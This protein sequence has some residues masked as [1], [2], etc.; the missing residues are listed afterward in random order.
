VNETSV[1]DTDTTPA[2][3]NG[4]PL[5]VNDAPVDNDDAPLT[6]SNDKPVDNETLETN[7]DDEEDELDDEETE[8]GLDSHKTALETPA[9][10]VALSSA[11]LIAV[12]MKEIEDMKTE[13]ARTARAHENQAEVVTGLQ[14]QLVERDR[15]PRRGRAYAMR[16][17]MNDASILALPAL[18][19]AP[20]LVLN[21]PKDAASI[22]WKKKR[23]DLMDRWAE[24]KLYN[25]S[26]TWGTCGTSE[27]KIQMVIPCSLCV[28]LHGHVK[29]V[30]VC[31]HTMFI[32]CA[33]SRT[34]QM[35]VRV[36]VTQCI[37]ASRELGWTCA[38]FDSKMEYLNTIRRK[39][40]H[41]KQ[42]SHAQLVVHLH[43][44]HYTAMF[45]CLPQI[46][47]YCRKFCRT[48]AMFLRLPQILP[49]CRKFCRTAAMFLRLPRLPQILPCMTTFNL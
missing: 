1:A 46:L 32:V 43:M 35:C 38:E 34:C 9:Q 25:P 41:V 14:Q 42:V 31:C 4:T 33:T 16:P 47:P 18:S 12:M 27:D 17:W 39:R 13:M 28:P 11:E 49:Y 36:Y 20:I 37:D 24:L 5:V 40:G 7:V 10:P 3:V 44:L 26:M 19:T 6:N 2:T 21:G 30:C 45:L 8:D 48:A 23:N 29:C 15:N 22:R